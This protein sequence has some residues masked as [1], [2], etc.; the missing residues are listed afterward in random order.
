MAITNFNPTREEVKRWGP[1]AFITAQERQAIMD[2]PAG[3]Y[4]R[5]CA[6]LEREISDLEKKRKKAGKPINWTWR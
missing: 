4:K 3:E 6:S 5:V 2:K 1:L